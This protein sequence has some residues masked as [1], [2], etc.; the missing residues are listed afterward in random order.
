MAKL[1]KLNEELGTDDTPKYR[2]DEGTFETD[3]YEIVQ[4]GDSHAPAGFQNIGGIEI[5]PGYRLCVFSDYNQRNGPVNNVCFDEGRHSLPKHSNR[6]PKNTRSYTLLKHCNH[7]SNMWDPECNTVND[8]KKVVYDNE[9]Y[10]NKIKYCNSLQPETGGQDVEHCA[11]FCR[12]KTGICDTYMTN[13]CKINQGKGLCKCINSPAN[14]PSENKNASL[15]GDVLYNPLCIDAECIRDGYATTIMTENRCQ[16][17]IDCGVYHDIKSRNLEMKYIDRDIAQ[18]CSAEAFL[19]GATDAKDIGARDIIT[20]A[21]NLNTFKVKS[22]PQSYLVTKLFLI[23]IIGILL[24]LYRVNAFRIC[25]SLGN[26]LCYGG[27]GAVV[28][29][30]VL[31]TQIA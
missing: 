29:L 5:A 18:R 31:I 3:N 8:S 27:I 1:F 12:G 13:Y 23:V 15:D 10:E 9:S 28:S 19:K 4:T 7:R 22:A 16:T 17:A 21:P 30:I 14:L 11:E 6:W 24:Y 2:L 26:P 20:V 25:L